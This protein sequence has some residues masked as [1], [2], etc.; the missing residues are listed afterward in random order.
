MIY[1]VLVVGAGVVGALTARELA[2]YHLNVLVLEAE[3]DA[4]MGATKANSAIVHGGFAEGPE[5]LKGRLCIAGRRQFLHLEQELNFGY[6]VTGSLVVSFDSDPSRLQALYQKGLANGLTDLELWSGHQVRDHEPNVNPAVT[7]ALWCAGAGVCSPW[8]LA[9]AAL[10]NAVAQGVEFRPGQRV[11]AVEGPS[12]WRLS[13][14]D[15]TFE[16]RFV[17]NAAGLGGG[18]LDA[19]A[20]IHDS[21]L[22]AR[23][24][25]YLVF[26]PGTG[27]LVNSVIFQL[28]GPMGK[29]VLVGPTYQNNLLIGPDARNEDATTELRHTHEERLAALVTQASQVVGGIELKKAIRSFTGVRA[30]ASTGDFL[31]GAANPH[32]KPGWHR[33]VGVQSPGLTASPALA[34]LLVDGLAAEGLSLVPRTEFDPTRRPLASHLSRRAALLPFAEADALTRLPAGHPDRVVCR[35]E[36]VRERDLAEAFSR[37]LPL[38]TV[39]ALKRRTRAGMGW[40]Q[41]RFCRPRVA[42]WLGLQLGHPVAADDDVA[43]SGVHRVEGREL[44]T[45]L[46]QRAPNQQS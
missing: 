43:R 22:T 25:E 14:N 18:S 41:G 40:C 1:D 7:G 31:V 11:R 38:T 5:T 23:S 27:S 15:T 33:A 34:R 36:Q 30:A 8:D 28:P 9:Y 10:E 24:G 44:T 35:C 12:P 39:D 2:R 46:D 3:P 26:A 42:E 32:T 37:G 6:R 19:L 4:A 16:A 45:L 20:G 29:G 13:T 21:S 17:V